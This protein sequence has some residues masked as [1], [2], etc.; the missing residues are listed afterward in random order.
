M[1]VYSESLM[2]GRTASRSLSFALSSWPSDSIPPMFLKHYIVP[3]MC[4]PSPSQNKDS[5]MEMPAGS[6]EDI[7]LSISSL[8]SILEQDI[9]YVFQHISTVTDTAVYCVRNLDIWLVRLG[10]RSALWRT[11]TQYYHIKSS[12]VTSV[13]EVLQNSIIKG[14]FLDEILD[15]LS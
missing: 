9:H 5:F 1:N 15:E 10:C 8:L 4:A 2:V 12:L 3:F 13:V 7:F 14:K 11:L 6:Q